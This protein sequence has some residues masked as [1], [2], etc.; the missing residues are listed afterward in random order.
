M[1]STPHG[2]RRSGA[3]RGVERERLI[4][5]RAREIEDA[6]AGL[7]QLDDRAQRA[8]E[9]IKRA[10]NYHFVAVQ[11][12]DLGEQIIQ[13]V[14]GSGIGGDWYK[15]ARH[16]LQGDPKFLDIQAHVA[17]ADPPAVEIIEGWD[18][19]FDRFIYEKFGH[20]H[21]VRAFVPLIVRR[22]SRNGAVGEADPG[23][24]RWERE[25]GAR[26]SAI[27]L[28]PKSN[29]GGPLR[30]YD[31]IGTVEAGF[32]NSGSAKRRARGISQA[33]AQRLFDHACKHAFALYRATLLHV[34][35]VITRSA[36]D[37]A[38]ADCAH[39]R[40]PFDRRQKRD[41]YPVWAGQPVPLGAR[42][43]LE[44]QA[45]KKTEPA[46]ASG[47][48]LAQVNP[49]AYAAGIRS[50]AA[51]PLIIREGPAAVFARR[52]S[53]EAKT[54]MLYVG[55]RHE[56]QFVQEKDALQLFANLAKNAIRQ[57]MHSVD[58]IHSARQLANLHDISGSL[59]HEAES[60]DLLGSIA[61]HALNILAADLVIIYEYDPAEQ[62]FRPNPAVAGQRDLPGTPDASYTPPPDLMKLKEIKYP[63][64]KTALAKLYAHARPDL[65]ETCRRFVAKEGLVAGAVVPLWSANDAAGLIF[66]NYRRPH[67]FSKYEHSIISTLASTAAIAIQQRRLL[68]AREE[69]VS[70]TTH[71]L[72]NSLG[73]IL[74]M[75]DALPH[76]CS[77]EDLQ[78]IA[79]YLATVHGWI[80]GLHVALGK[81]RGKLVDEEE[82]D[83]AQE[84]RWIWEL[85]KST[86]GR[87]KL[88][89]TLV[90]RKAS[91]CT[92]VMSRTV[93]RN[94]VYC[95]LDNAAKYGDEGSELLVECEDGP[96]TIKVHSIGLPIFAD[97]K[98]AIFQK[99]RQGRAAAGFAGIGLGLWVTRQLAELAEG[100][101]DVELDAADER[102]KTFV[103]QLP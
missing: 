81:D 9:E 65:E 38:H 92:A 16:P 100:S 73:A 63:K 54:G 88:K 70:A 49:E 58:T 20:E 94:V 33:N 51:Y 101:I 98:K 32:D 5:A 95:L 26:R 17:L 1:P 42:G 96:T 97:E 72:Q 24:F 30:P 14:Y 21:F 4:L 62:L 3:A 68:R 103:F 55:F 64:S 67:H 57:A 84:V 56:H 28:T 44:D 7:H 79:E 76:P 35:E 31:I 12:I 22:D 80:K 48:L 43:G 11:L 59:A 87:G 75:F 40:F 82:I 91:S 8:C 10:L 50:L 61:G 60:A 89:F 83:I 25:G 69:S 53:P 93:I 45:I 15:I 99:F 29:R 85:V 52:S 74:D 18:D 34:L 90:N 47:E 77:P 36:L 71:Q 46:S 86:P 6:T 13:T 2:T 102:K 66:V 23:E 19:R 41:P 78:R 39:L 27:R 37:V